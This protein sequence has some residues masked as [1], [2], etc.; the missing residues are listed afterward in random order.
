MF[1]IFLKIAG[2]S[3]GETFNLLRRMFYVNSIFLFVP[4]RFASVWHH[5]A[6]RTQMDVTQNFLIASENSDTVRRSEKTKGQPKGR[7]RLGDTLYLCVHLLC[8]PRISCLRRIFPYFSA[9]RWLP[10]LSFGI[11]TP[12]LCLC[13]HYDQA[14][15]WYRYICANIS[16]YHPEYPAFAEYSLSLPA[17]ARLPAF[18]TL[19]SAWL[20]RPFFLRKLQTL[21]LFHP[22][23]VNRKL[24]T[25]LREHSRETPCS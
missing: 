17:G 5:K 2:V 18:R 21:G 16:W 19:R 3:I 4:F 24:K 10:P 13:E 23:C 1:Y 20:F 9:G 25:H 11:Q 14:S 15:R 8:H 22:F 6:K 12:S 7:V